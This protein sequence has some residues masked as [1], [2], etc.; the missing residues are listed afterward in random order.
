MGHS[1]IPRPFG[2]HQSKL[3]A[4]RFRFL[5]DLSP[6]AF[7]MTI[8]AVCQ[9]QIRNTSR[10]EMPWPQS[11]QPDFNRASARALPEARGEAVSMSLEL[12]LATPR[13]GLGLA[14]PVTTT[15]MLGLRF[16]SRDRIAP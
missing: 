7:I 6:L 10:R 14:H 5:R 1:P 11:R 8:P 12:P 13:H 2:G 15:L 9:I 4:A 3:E 16:K